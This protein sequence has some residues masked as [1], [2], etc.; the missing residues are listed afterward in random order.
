M[1]DL[2]GLAKKLIAVVVG[3]VMKANFNPFTTRR[4]RHR[5]R[6]L[7]FILFYLLL[8]LLILMLA[9]SL[10]IKMVLY[11]SIL[12]TGLRIQAI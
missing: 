4:Q 2:D 8:S 12:F 3:K 6:Q 11:S 7:I 1:K 5:L 9:L 10:P